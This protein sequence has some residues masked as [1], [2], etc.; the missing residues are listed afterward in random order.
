MVRAIKPSRGTAGQRSRVGRAR[1]DVIERVSMGCGRP[2]LL[3]RIDRGYHT[4]R[5]RSA[6][7]V[8]SPHRSTRTNRQG[9]EQDRKLT[10]SIV[11]GSRGK[12]LKSDRSSHIDGCDG[13]VRPSAWQQAGSEE[14]E[15]ETRW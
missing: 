11:G 4:R 12:G 6:R 9:D 5:R 14:R 15:M 10:Y 3:G 8:R 1:S 13:F 7:P 2:Q